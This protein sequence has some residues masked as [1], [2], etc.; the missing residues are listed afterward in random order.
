MILSQTSRSRSRYSIWRSGRIW[1][2]K[3]VV[4]ELPGRYLRDAARSC[5]V[6]TG[7]QASLWL[8]NSASTNT[9]LVSGV[10]GF[11]TGTGQIFNHSPGHGL[12]RATLFVAGSFP[13]L[14]TQGLRR[15]HR[16]GAF[17][18]RRGR[19]RRRVLLP[20]VDSRPDPGR[21]FRCPVIGHRNCSHLDHRMA[22]FSI[23]VWTL[24]QCSASA[25]SL[26]ARQ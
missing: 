14:G 8:L 26:R 25:R 12:R 2:G 22:P 15:I 24:R 21:Y 18:N 4:T 20:V 9:P 10:A 3:F 6:R 11:S 13:T 7:C 1:R 17:G 19:L 16:A 5:D 23:S